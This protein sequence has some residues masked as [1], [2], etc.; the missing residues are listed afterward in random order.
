MAVP[1]QPTTVTH[2][3][4][5]FIKFKK[6]PPFTQINKR[7]AQFVRWANKAQRAINVSLLR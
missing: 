7:L 4:Y 6:N 3:L 1:V 5:E 2:H